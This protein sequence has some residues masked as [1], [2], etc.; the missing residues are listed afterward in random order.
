MYGANSGSTYLPASVSLEEIRS[1]ECEKPSS[2]D[3]NDD[4]KNR[5]GVSTVID[6]K[7]GDTIV[8][9][10]NMLPVDIDVNLAD[11]PIGKAEVTSLSGA[12]R[13]TDVKPEVSEINLNG[14]ITVPPYSFTVIRIY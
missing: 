11:Y 4:V 10:A 13:Q 9:I 3:L 14:E 6:E 12:P 1:G 5:F 7:T 8:R 2:K